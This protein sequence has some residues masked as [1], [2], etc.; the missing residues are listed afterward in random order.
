MQIE[1][2]VQA[3]YRCILMK[4]RVGEEIEGEVTSVAEHGVV[5]TIDAPFVE[6]KVPI[7]RIGEDYFELDRL[8]IALVGSR[9]GRRVA[10]A[11]RVRVRIDDASI[12]RREIT[13]TLLSGG[14]TSTWSSGRMR[15]NT[16]AF[17]PAESARKKVSVATP[18]EMPSAATQN[19]RI[20]RRRSRPAR[21][22]SGADLTTPPP[23]SA[24]RRR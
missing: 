15:P 8:G 13:A 4:K 14:I 5:I 16:T 9:S 2:E 12:E 1:R 22:K 18:A 17:M 6:V 11:D 3:I 20:E 21:A 7:D 23:G 19:V 24:G 10:L